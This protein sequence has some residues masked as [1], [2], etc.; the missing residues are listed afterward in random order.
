[1]LVQNSAWIN[2][3]LEVQDKSKNWNV[4]TMGIRFYIAAKLLK[5]CNLSNFGI[6]SKNIHNYL[7]LVNIY[8]CNSHK[9]KLLRIVRILRV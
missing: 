2:D 6:V 5:G 9:Q 8:K 4:K 3:P 1:M 7:N